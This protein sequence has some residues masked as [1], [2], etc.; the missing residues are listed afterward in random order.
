MTLDYELRVLGM[1]GYPIVSSLA[2]S[3]NL[4]VGKAFH[5]LQICLLYP[6]PYVYDLT[7]TK[8]ETQGE[9]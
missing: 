7:N 2:I 6:T 1:L 8:T 5:T 3:W 4:W 9:I